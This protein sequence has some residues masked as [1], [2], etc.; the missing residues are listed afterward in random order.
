MS[1]FND[2][3]FHHGHVANAELA[4]SLAAPKDPAPAPGP[5]PQPQDSDANAAQAAPEAKRAAARARR[6]SALLQAMTALSPFR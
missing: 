5:A 2:L 1:I 4:R 3:L 6:H